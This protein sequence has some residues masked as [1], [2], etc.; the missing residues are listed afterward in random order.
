MPTASLVFTGLVAFIHVYIFVLEQF[1]YQ[2]R[3]GLRVFGNTP[4][5]AAAT[6][7]FA[8]NQ[9]WY[10]LV[11]A[12][13]LVWA[14]VSPDPSA[15]WQLK[16]VLLGAVAVVGVVGAVTVSIRILFV[17]TVPAALGLVFTLLAR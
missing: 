17:Q 15:A 1:L 11:L 13:G 14:V 2:K 9:A 8:T 3:V 10:N 16:L 5:R 4:E 6:Q 7:V 12:A